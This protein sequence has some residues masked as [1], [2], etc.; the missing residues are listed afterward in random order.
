MIILFLCLLVIKAPI[1][2]VGFISSLSGMA[3]GVIFYIATILLEAKFAYITLILSGFL[4]G[5][6]FSTI[7]FDS[8]KQQKLYAYSIILSIA[9]GL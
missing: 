4:I 1:P 3:A 7:C 5:G 8:V 9:Y 2:L 6:T